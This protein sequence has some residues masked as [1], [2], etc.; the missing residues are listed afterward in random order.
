ME[1]RK[2]SIVNPRKKWSLTKKLL[3]ITMAIFSVI[4]INGLFVYTKDSNA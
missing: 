1:N 4:L 3:F 2:K